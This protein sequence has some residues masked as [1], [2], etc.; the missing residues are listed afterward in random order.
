MSVENKLT[1]LHEMLCDELI[2]RLKDGDGGEGVT[3]PATFNV[4]RQFLKDN[5]V[6]F[7]D[8]DDDNPMAELMRDLPE[9]LKAQFNKPQ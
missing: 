8:G 3:T 1:A 2:A 6:E 5:H 9:S 7:L 4:I